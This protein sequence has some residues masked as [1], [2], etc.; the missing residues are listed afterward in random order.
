MV[1]KMEDYFCIAGLLLS[2]IMPAVRMSCLGE[3]IVET[4]IVRA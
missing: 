3:T 4:D 2:V 1:N